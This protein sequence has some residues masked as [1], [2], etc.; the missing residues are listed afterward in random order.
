MIPSEVLIRRGETTV[1]FV[2]KNDMVEE[3]AVRVGYVEGS[4][5][6]ISEGLTAGETIVTL[7]QQGLRDGMRVRTGTDRE[8]PSRQQPGR[9]Q[10]APAASPGGGRP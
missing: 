6:E 4:R 7:G 10:P 8:Q 2:V 5:S 9:Q 1:V 3:R